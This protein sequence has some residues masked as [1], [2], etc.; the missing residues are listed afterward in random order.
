MVQFLLLVLLYILSGPG[1]YQKVGQGKYEAPVF[2]QGPRDAGA[3][4]GL[5]SPAPGRQWHWGW[6]QTGV[7]VTR[8]PL[9]SLSPWAGARW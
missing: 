3:L 2:R 5:A 1:P 7:A 6:V 8:R 4:S 9:W